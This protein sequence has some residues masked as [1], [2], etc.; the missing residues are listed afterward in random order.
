MLSID[1]FGN[2]A[3]TANEKDVGVAGVQVG[4]NVV[5]QAKRRLHDLKVV[6]TFSDAPEAKP[7]VLVGSHGLLEVAINRGSAA[8]R[9]RVVPGDKLIFMSGRGY[10]S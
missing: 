4:R 7:V 6:R 5:M 3:T 1:S 2:I 9:F 10:R 8:K